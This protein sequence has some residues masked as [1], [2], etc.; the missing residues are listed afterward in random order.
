MVFAKVI[1]TQLTL[2]TP[3]IS[4]ME[5]SS[6]RGKSTSRWRNSRLALELVAGFVRVFGSTDKPYLPFVETLSG[7]YCVHTKGGDGMD[8]V[9]GRW[10]S[11]IQ[12]VASEEKEHLF[13]GCD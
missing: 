9:R 11:E 4:A 12:A 7:W 8:Q 13:H 6:F 1:F 2:Q 5:C 3:G 10:P